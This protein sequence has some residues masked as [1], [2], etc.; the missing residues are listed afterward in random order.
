MNF[1]VMQDREEK[2]AMGR[3]M[4]EYGESL[5]NYVIG[6]MVGAMLSTVL[7]VISLY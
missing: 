5:N 2:K 6:T 4:E 7:I 3:I 1:V